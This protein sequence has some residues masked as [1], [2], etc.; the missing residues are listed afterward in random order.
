MNS[1]KPYKCE[2]YRNNISSLYVKASQVVIVA[3]VLQSPDLQGC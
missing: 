2:H 3:V 1:F